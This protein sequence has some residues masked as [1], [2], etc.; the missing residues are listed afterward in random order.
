MNTLKEIRQQ[1]ALKRDAKEVAEGLIAIFKHLEL[2][3]EL[4]RHVVKELRQ[5]RSKLAKLVK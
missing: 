3:R 1:R 5:R 4:A 2:D